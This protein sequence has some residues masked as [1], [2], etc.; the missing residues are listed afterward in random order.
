MTN[1]F[2]DSG[3]WRRLCL[4]CGLVGVGLFGG[5]SLGSAQTP[6]SMQDILAEDSQSPPGAFTTTVAYVAQFYPLWFTYYQSQLGTFNRL[7]GPDR[8]SP[9]YHFVVLINDD[10]LYASSFL[11]LTTEPA[12]LA[13]PA[14][15][16]T[17]SLLNL[18]PNGDI[19]QTD[20]PPQTA[21]VYAFTGPG[22]SG[23]L[24]SGLTQIEMPLNIS[25]LIFRADK[26]SSGQNQINE[27]ETFRRSLM[28]QPLSDYLQNPSGGAAAIIPEI[29]FAVPFKTTADLLVAQDPISFLKQLQRA[30]AAPN[31]PPLSPDE[32]ALSNRFD[33]LF[34]NGNRQRAEFS[35]GAQ[36]AHQLI[37]DSY[38]THTG[39][40]NW[41]HFT[42]I[43]NWGNHIVERSAITEFCQYCND[44]KSAAYY[45]TFNDIDG[46]PLDGRDPR[47]YVLTF[48]VGQIPIAERFWSLTAYTPQ[49]IELVPNPADKY[50]VASYTPGL[51]YNADG[52]LSVYLSR[53]PPAGVPVAN[54]LPIPFS[55]FN[56]AL[57]VYG[58]EGDVENNTYVPPGIRRR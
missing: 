15:S 51:K 16:V 58:P 2:Q 14:T 47:G 36:A 50:V 43:G 56:I 44:I 49:A 20:I 30:V 5:S 11:D 24:P 48:P 3:F 1:H 38:L 17:Y 45:H 31:T 35:A 8:I 29:A 12:I 25:T 55:K 32:Q 23:T 46:R 28:L 27:A 10:T 52:S 39:P 18:T 13:I 54:W 37:I 40:T 42:N 26:Y 33:A 34:G 21:G 53:M 7:A 4:V 57:R 22:F 41:I 19:F 9:L 6:Q